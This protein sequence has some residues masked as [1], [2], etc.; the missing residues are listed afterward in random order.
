LDFRRMPGGCRLRRWSCHLSPQIGRAAGRRLHLRLGLERPLPDIFGNRNIR[1]RTRAGLRL[2]RPHGGVVE[3]HRPRQGV[4]GAAARGR[5]FAGRGAGAHD[6]H[7]DHDVGRPADHQEMLDIVAADQDEL[8]AGI[9]LGGVDD[10]QSR[11]AAARARRGEAIGP[12]P[13]DQPRSR[14]NEDENDDEGE[15]ELH[16]Q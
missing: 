3:R 16:R 12:E 7:L 10:G 13:A 9:D 8:A 2:Q 1:A 11:L 14:E 4:G 15:Q 5:R 6:V